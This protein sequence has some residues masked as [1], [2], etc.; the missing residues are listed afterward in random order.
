MSFLRSLTESFCLKRD[1]DSDATASGPLMKEYSEEN[2]TNPVP[3]HF[4]LGKMF[5]SFHRR[6]FY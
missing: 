4:A 5:H 2:Q 3:L 6:V 1:S